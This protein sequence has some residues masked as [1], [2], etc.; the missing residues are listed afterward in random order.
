MRVM[1]EA[2]ESEFDRQYNLPLWRRILRA[3]ILGCFLSEYAWYRRACGGHWERWHIESI[4]SRLWLNVSRCSVE[5][6]IRPGDCFGTPT[7]EDHE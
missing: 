5:T 6:G 2:E 7:C 3:R 4:H 1:T